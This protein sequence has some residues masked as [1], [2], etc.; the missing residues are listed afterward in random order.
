MSGELRGQESLCQASGTSLLPREVAA[1]GVC[2][3]TGVYLENHGK[4]PHAPEGE[5]PSSSAAIPAPYETA[6]AER[7]V[8][9]PADANSENQAVFVWPQSP[10]SASVRVAGERERSYLTLRLFLPFF[11]LSVQCGLYPCTVRIRPTPEPLAP[12][13]V[14]VRPLNDTTLQL[15]KPPCFSSKSLTTPLEVLSLGSAD[16]PLPLPVYVECLESE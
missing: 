12:R 1:P 8:L 10:P 3:D 11:L 7:L 9:N 4:R 13:A 15:R 6:S 5:E 16:T 2:L 14:A